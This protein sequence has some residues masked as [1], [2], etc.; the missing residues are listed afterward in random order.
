MKISSANQNVLDLVTKL[1]WKQKTVLV[2]PLIEQFSMKIAERVFTAK[3]TQFM[4]TE[5]VKSVPGLALFGVESMGVRVIHKAS[6]ENEIM[7]EFDFFETLKRPRDCMGSRSSWLCTV[8][9]KSTCRA[10]FVYK[11]FGTWC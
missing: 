6:F 3:K 2:M 8:R 1:T 10:K 11:L 7:L 5:N 9:F 4:S